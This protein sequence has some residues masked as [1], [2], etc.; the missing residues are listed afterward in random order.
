MWH[1]SDS[2]SAKKDTK[3]PKEEY[4]ER[5]INSHKYVYEKKAIL[6]TEKEAIVLKFWINFK[7][8]A[9]LHR[10]DCMNCK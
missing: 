10:I 2:E 3:I 8:I 4:E 6:E 1:H 9:A 7:A 5:I